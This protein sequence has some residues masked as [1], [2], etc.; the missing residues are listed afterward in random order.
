MTTQ[1]STITPTTLDLL[2]QAR[3]LVLTPAEQREV[4]MFF[5]GYAPELFAHELDRIVALRGTDPAIAVATEIGWCAISRYTGA[6]I[7]EIAEAIRAGEL[8][9]QIRA[10]RRHLDNWVD[11]RRSE[12]AEIALGDLLGQIDGAR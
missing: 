1:S 8:R 6:S 3:G 9:C 12:A 4:L 11:A 10:E 2:E 7:A 5:A